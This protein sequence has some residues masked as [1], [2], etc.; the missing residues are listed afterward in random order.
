MCNAITLTL[1]LAGWQYHGRAIALVRTPV[2]DKLY[3]E[4][5]CRIK[6]NVGVLVGQPGVGKTES[7]RELAEVELGYQATIV[8]STEVCV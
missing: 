3:R 7:L 8:F 2:T 6:M 5:L 4:V 1:A